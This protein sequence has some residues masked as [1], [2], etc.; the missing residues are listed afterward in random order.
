VVVQGQCGTFVGHAA[1]KSSKPTAGC[2]APL[3]CAQPRAAA[4]D[5]ERVRWCEMA[6]RRTARILAEAAAITARLRHARIF[7]APIPF[8][9]YLIWYPAQQRRDA[10][11]AHR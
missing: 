9:E 8:S 4:D 3:V 7:S 10:Y 1:L 5:G 2:A 6:P 11:R